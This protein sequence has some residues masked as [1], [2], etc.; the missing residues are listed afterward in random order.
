MLNIRGKNKIH[1]KPNRNQGLDFIL[2]FQSSFRDISQ[3]IDNYHLVDPFAFKYNLNGIV[4][5][6]KGYKFEPINN[7]DRP[8]RAVRKREWTEHAETFTHYLVMMFSRAWIH[9]EEWTGLNGNQATAGKLT[10]EIEEQSLKHFIPFFKQVLEAGGFSTRLPIV[11]VNKA[12]V[13][14]KVKLRKRKSIRIL[15]FVLE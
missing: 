15:F 2:K 11:D 14:D 9:V 1:V 3:L 10:V 13:A 5:F 8:F 7:Y 4:P 12:L 6:K